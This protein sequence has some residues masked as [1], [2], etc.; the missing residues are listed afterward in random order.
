MTGDRERLTDEH[1]DRVL[2]GSR[3]RTP[4][5][6][7]LVDHDLEWA[8]R[9]EEHRGR[10]VAA[11]GDR[12]VRVEH[13]GSTSVPGLRAKPRIDVLVTVDD[14]E[15]DAAIERLE[16]AGYRLTVR[17]PGHRCLV[18]QPGRGLDANVHVWADHDPEV[19]RYLL[20]RDR[21]RADAGDRARYQARK[22]ELAARLWTDVDR[23]AEAKGEVVEAIIARAREDSGRLST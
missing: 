19:E 18:A 23:Y 8:L 3:D 4:R 6:V 20:F 5:P 13:I 16:A 15:D 14:A 21:L 9:F 12:V 17:E 1:L 22:E 2:V 10:V 7:V 11:L